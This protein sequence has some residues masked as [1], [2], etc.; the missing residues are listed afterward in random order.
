MKK[1]QQMMIFPPS[2]TPAKKAGDQILRQT[3]CGTTNLMLM[4]P[5]ETVSE[6]KYEIKWITRL[7]LRKLNMQQRV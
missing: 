6:N 3:W 7:Q 5:Q 4:D 2:C 1:Q